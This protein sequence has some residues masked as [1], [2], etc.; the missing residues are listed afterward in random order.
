MNQD[1][2]DFDIKYRPRTLDEVVGQDAAVKTIKSFKGKLPRAILLHGASG[3]SKTTLAR[4]MA[5]EILKVD[6]RSMDFKEVNCGM[7]PSAIDMVRDL[8]ASVTASAI[9]AGG[10]RVWILDEVQ[11]LSQTPRAQELLLKVLE[12]SQPHIQFFLATTEPARLKL[13][14][15][16]RCVEIAIK[17]IKPTDLTTLVDRIAKAEKIPLTDEV[18]E[19]IVALANGGA[20]DAVKA[21]QKIAGLNTEAEQLEALGTGFGEDTPEFEIVKALDLYRG[22][23]T[24]NWARVK[25]KLTALDEADPE[26]IRCMILAAAR[27]ALLKGTNPGLC[28]KVIMGLSDPM[29]DRR[30]G[31]AV[32]AAR[33]WAV[34]NSK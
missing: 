15:R 31:K 12:D 34:C 17:P 20:R 28:Y 25:D 9:I 32:L 33:L 6:D 11:V 16:N 29:D 30:S 23:S 13:A 22:G 7:A 26:G 5:H 10:K 8:H 14:I 19:R 1:V 18:R 27:T 2:R 3:C 4:I 24:P 21:L